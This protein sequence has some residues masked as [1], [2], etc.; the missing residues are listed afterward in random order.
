MYNESSEFSLVFFSGGTALYELSLFLAKTFPYSTHIIT[1]FDSGGSSASLRKAFN[2]PAVG[3]LRN[4]LIALANPKI[5]LNLLNNL[6][7]RLPLDL[8]SAKQIFQSFLEAKHSF[9]QSLPENFRQTAYSDFCH[10]ARQNTDFL[11]VG[12]SFGNLLLTAFW[13]KHGQS[14]QKAIAEYGR[15]LDIQG[16]ILAVQEL[17]LH[18]AAQLANGQIIVGQHLFQKQISPIQEIFL[19]ENKPDENSK[20]TTYT[21]RITAEVAKSLNC[22]KLICY[23][24]GSF[25]SSILANLLPQGTGESIANNPCPKIFI[26]NSGFDPEIANLSIVQQVEKIVEIL[27]KD[28]PSARV[29]DFI[30]D[31]LLDTQNGAYKELDIRQLQ[32]YNIHIH[33]RKIVNS[34]DANKHLAEN[35]AKFLLQ[36]IYND[37]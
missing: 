37:A 11:P 28:C 5:P 35:V 8:A 19:T 25:Y 29:K 10:L 17:N 30:S 26:P 33:D 24:M 9:W 22:A 7:Y 16:K 1:T 13:L 31:I 21:A 23:P 32:G 3:D 18:L 36:Y 34:E 12:A 20:I 6:K 2:I 27:R 14:L 15:L 4:R